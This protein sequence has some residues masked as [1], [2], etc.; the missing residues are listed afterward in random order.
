MKLNVVIFLY[1]FPNH[2]EPIVDD[3]LNSLIISGLYDESNKILLSVVS[4]NEELKKFKESK[5]KKYNKIE[6]YNVSDENFF[7]FL[8]LHSVFELS[9]KE[10]G[11]ILYLHSKGVT[12]G[13]KS[14]KNNK[15]RKF[16][17]KYLVN[18]YRIVVSK[19][20]EDKSIDLYSV[21]PSNDG[22]AWY[23]FFWVRSEYVRNNCIP[24]TPTLDRYYWEKWIS[25]HNNGV[26]SYSPIIGYRGLPHGEELLSLVN[27]E[28]EKI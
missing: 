16:N 25:L 17:L 4:N 5:L 7:E 14:D 15:I 19:F 27:K 21:F 10:D 23:N 9:K 20:K 24:P 1:L 22:F 2:W 12:S 11:L 18:D 28:I 6:I 26:I 13:I 8:G 3:I